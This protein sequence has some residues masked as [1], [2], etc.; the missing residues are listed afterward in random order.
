VHVGRRERHKCTIRS[1]VFLDTHCLNTAEDWQ[2]GFLRGIRNAIV[3]AIL[4]SA[5]SLRGVIEKSAAGQDN[6]LLEIEM[7][8]ERSAAGTCQVLPCFV[9]E[10]HTMQVDGANQRFLQKFGGD[11]HGFDVSRFPAAKHAS[12]ASTTAHT[13]RETMEALFKLQGIHVDPD[14][15][16]HTREQLFETI[17]AASGALAAD[18][19]PV[20]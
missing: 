6:Y 18:C 20:D 11:G 1:A 13:V 3:I 16:K 14:A 8:L 10:Y 5:K 12:D 17:C 15:L 7:A 9:G 4:I 19:Q 2:V